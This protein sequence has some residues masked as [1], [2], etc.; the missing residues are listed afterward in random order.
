M[1]IRF[2]V[3]QEEL[4][5][6][7]AA[8]GVNGAPALDPSSHEARS[9]LAAIC[10][11]RELSPVSEVRYW[12]RAAFHGENERITLDD[13]M[14]WQ[15]MGEALSCHGPDG[16]AGVEEDLYLEVKGGSTPEWLSDTLGERP[17]AQVSKLLIATAPLAA[18]GFL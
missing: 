5:L 2:P 10:R 6:I 17:A 12:R 9:A 1:K 16:A 14:R 3:L 13:D 15:L 7:L 8:G 18:G 4:P 11:G